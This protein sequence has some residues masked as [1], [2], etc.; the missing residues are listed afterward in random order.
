MKSVYE[1]FEFNQVKK[2]IEKY[3]KTELGLE[4][5]RN[6]EMFDNEFDLKNELVYM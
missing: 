2:L 6:L 3:S 4:M 5:I 1:V